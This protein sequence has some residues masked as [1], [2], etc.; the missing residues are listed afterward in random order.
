MAG[1]NIFN[2]H[3]LI[4]KRP[5]LQIGSIGSREDYLV[6]FLTDGGIKI[7]AGCFSG[8]I[9]EFEKAVRKTHGDNQHGKEYDAALAMIKAHAE[10]WNPVMAGQ[11][12]VL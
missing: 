6:A 4:G 8:S 7:K 12:V 11:G 3:I 10:I 9:E 1:A 5:I 2:G